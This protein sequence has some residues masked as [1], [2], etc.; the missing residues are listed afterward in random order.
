MLHMYVLCM[1]VS[2][3]HVCI[4]STLINLYCRHARRVLLIFY[5]YMCLLN[6]SFVPTMNYFTGI[7]T[8][9]EI[10]FNFQ[11]LFNYMCVVV[12]ARKIKLLSLSI[13]MWAV[14]VHLKYGVE[15][16][17][18]VWG[19]GVCCQ[20]CITVCKQD[21]HT[22]YVQSGPSKLDQLAKILNFFNKISWPIIKNLRLYIHQIQF[23]PLVIIDISLCPFQYY[24]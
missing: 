18:Y 12:R 8:W 22:V 2:S 19:T 16:I 20:C 24:A 13:R 3:M 15:I 9:T 1:Y 4:I 6:C 10:C 14:L 17:G 7:H 5:S 11:I 21:V 23:S